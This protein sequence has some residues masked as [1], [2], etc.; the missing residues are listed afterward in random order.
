MTTHHQLA[1]TYR[2]IAFFRRLHIQALS[3]ML[4]AAATG[5]IGILAALVI[6]L[7]GGS[8]AQKRVAFVGAGL[9]WI[10]LL[11]IMLR[12]YRQARRCAAAEKP[13]VDLIERITMRFMVDGMLSR[14]V[15]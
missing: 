1:D 10:P 4:L 5:M 14:D 6:V 15:Q 3:R 7:I 2:E 9:A 8:D 13:Y 11:V 12:A